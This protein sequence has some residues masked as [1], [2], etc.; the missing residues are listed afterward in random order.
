VGDPDAGNPCPLAKFNGHI[1]RKTT[2][3]MR[4][5]FLRAIIIML[6]KSL[7]EVSQSEEGNVGSGCG[8]IASLQAGY[9]EGSR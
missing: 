3:L 1:L 6:L 5:E 7:K 8:P 4:F 9:R 2:G